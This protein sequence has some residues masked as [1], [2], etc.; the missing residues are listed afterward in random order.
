VRKPAILWGLGSSSRMTDLIGKQIGSYTVLRQLGAGAMGEV[1]L[2]EHRHLK[3]KAAVKLLARELV[4]RPELLE[5]FFLEARATSAIAHPGIVQIFDCEVDSTGRP[6]IVMEYLAGDTLAATLARRGVLPPI[7]VARM[8][9]GMAEALAAAHAKGIVHRDL[10]PENIF[11][12]AEPPDAIKIVDFGI[13]KLAGDFQAGQVHKT[14]SGSVLGTPLYM[15][16][17]QCR[18]S[19]KT[20]YRTDLYS[21]GCVMFEMLTRQPPFVH[22]ALGDLVVAHMTA[23]PKDVRALNPSVPAPLAQLVGE[24][25]RKEPATRPADMRIVAERLMTFLAR[26]TTLPES[27]PA[28]T[29]APAARPTTGSTTFGEAASELSSPDVL[30]DVP[31]R[32]RRP[33]LVAAA[34]LG[35]ALI[36]GA[37]AATRAGKS[38]G[39]AKLAAVTG[40]ATP[41][42]PTVVTAENAA[43]TKPPTKVAHAA[44]NDERAASTGRRTGGGA[45]SPKRR[46]AEGTPGPAAPSA[47]KPASVAPGSGEPAGANPDSVEPPR[48][49]PSVTAP[50]PAPRPVVASPAPTRT[51]AA[52]PG[53]AGDWEG[54]WT[55]PD[56]HQNGRLSLHVAADGA[57]TGWMAN[58]VAHQTFRMVGRLSPAGTLDLACQ[59]P[60]SQGFFARGAVRRAEG[61]EMTGQL[62][63]ST[64]AAVFGQ[65]HLTLTRR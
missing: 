32:S 64:G 50:P 13:A 30:D 43:P 23:P 35:V 2:A 31:A 18:D 27:S 44:P 52:A 47:A 57:V 7:T 59:C 8:V 41:P 4:D 62:A 5:R 1:L 12:E 26:A 36:G 45:A 51:S 22:D 46:L 65:S 61:S 15:S 38:P 53:F 9:R 11:V 3:R 49:S 19:A 10:K 56:K 58:T 24:L 37:L 25:L 6:Y 48:V 16:P 21:L 54:P 34:I 29:T 60:P 17:E 28:T 42:T 39:A 63:L 14:R 55:D 20:D 33:L 40:N